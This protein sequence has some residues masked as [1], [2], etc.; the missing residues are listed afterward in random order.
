ML[1]TRTIFALSTALGLFACSPSQTVVSTKPVAT[2]PAQPSEAVSST[3]C[4]IDLAP[5]WEKNVSVHPTELN[6]IKRV[7]TAR[8][9]FKGDDQTDSFDGTASLTVGH[10]SRQEASDFPQKMLEL[11]SN[12]NDSR[13]LDSRKK[14]L[15]D[16]VAALEMAEL[17]QGDDGS[18]KI[19]LVV[20]AVK[21]D[22]AVLASCGT[23]VEHA[24]DVLPECEHVVSSLK[25]TS[26]KK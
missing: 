17:R 5:E 24:E 23:E 26:N 21:D 12:S 20:A 11:L 4:S 19:F 25:F 6:Q 10:L 7:V 13:V 8:K 2:K 22:L 15:S 14:E 16:G 1:N 9:T 18:L 3:T